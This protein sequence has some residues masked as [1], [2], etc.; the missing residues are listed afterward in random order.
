MVLHTV[1][2][3][4]TCYNVARDIIRLDVL[5]GSSYEPTKSEVRSEERYAKLRQ[6]L[7]C[8][9]SPKGAYLTSYFQADLACIK[10]RGGSH[11]L[12]PSKST[13]RQS[14]VLDR[15]SSHLPRGPLARSSSGKE[16]QA[17]HSTGSL[18]RLGTLPRQDRM[19][20]TSNTLFPE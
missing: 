11:T 5:L 12:S 14:L 8:L 18:T 4:I 10:G 1:S 15:C 3:T 17:H 9:I 19:T 20:L 13:A 16:L 7:N 2:E 6:E